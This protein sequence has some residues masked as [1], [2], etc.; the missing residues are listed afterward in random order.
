MDDVVLFAS[1]NVSIHAPHEGV[2][3]VRID[4]GSRSMSFNPRTPRGGATW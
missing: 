4:G 3:L 1:L 2:R